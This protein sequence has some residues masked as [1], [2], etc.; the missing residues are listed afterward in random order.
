MSEDSKP[1]E[2][3]ASHS[4]DTSIHTDDLA[5][6]ATPDPVAEHP[7]EA[8]EEPDAD[9][10]LE[11]NGATTADESLHNDEVEAEA[12]N[13]LATENESLR[14]QVEE[15]TSQCMRIAADFDNFRKRTD[16]EKSELELRVKRDAIS[17]LLP[18]I[19]S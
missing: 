6:D 11:A 19:D 8:Q 4:E 10:N 16:R 7:L 15:R 9:L 12:L 5:S 14:L 17:E 18:V 3:H 2:T 13:Q 1:L